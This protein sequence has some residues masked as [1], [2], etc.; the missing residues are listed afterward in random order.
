MRSLLTYNLGYRYF[1]SIRE[2]ALKNDK[3][4]RQG[5]L[6]PCLFCGHQ[7]FT[8]NSH[9]L[10]QCD[11]CNAQFDSAFWSTDVNQRMEDDWF[12][13]SYELNLSFW[14]REL[15]IRNHIRIFRRMS[16]YLKPEARILEVGVG[17]AG[18]LKFLR[19][20]GYEVS[21]CD[22]SE[23][24]CQNLRKYNIPAYRGLAEIPKD[25]KFDLVIANHV[26]EHTNVPHTLLKETRQVL[27]SS[28]LLHLAVPNVLS[29]GANF[30]SWVSYQPYH[31]VY[32]D[33]RSLR[34]VLVQSGF[35]VVELR[36][37]ESFTGW[38]LIVFRTFMGHKKTIETS[39]S[40]LNK[41]NPWVKYGYYIGMIIG[42][43][44]LTPL[45]IVQRVFQRGDEI[46]IVAR[47]TH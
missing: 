23:T 6:E 31:L 12:G 26:L 41:K 29:W 25:L 20:K 15:Q 22:L 2:E 17:N 33:E 3:L 43:F 14:E 37:F 39:N 4:A 44:V 19:N 35:E 5:A 16:S 8:R 40:I 13:E 21:G 11:C 9:S 24:L 46:H 38:F 45:R 10:I 36:F 30:K 28:G 1:D 27:S 7:E 42:S 47:P 32:F 18:L 34:C